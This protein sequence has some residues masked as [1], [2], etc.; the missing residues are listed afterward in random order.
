MST[1]RPSLAKGA[2]REQIN[3][4]YRAYRRKNRERLRAYHRIYIRFSSQ[5]TARSIEK[6]GVPGSVTYAQV[7]HLLYYRRD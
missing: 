6:Q 4:Y 2:T 3:A 1:I 7:S 5:E